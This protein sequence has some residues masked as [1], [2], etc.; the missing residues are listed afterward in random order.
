ML[1]L[2]ANKGS[3]SYVKKKRSGFFLQASSKYVLELQLRRQSSTAHFCCGIPPRWRWWL[4]TSAVALP[5]S[6]SYAS[7]S[8]HLLPAL[9][10]FTDSVGG[11]CRTQSYVPRCLAQNTSICFMQKSTNFRLVLMEVEYIWRFVIH[12]TPKPVSSIS[13]ISNFSTAMRFAFFREKSSF[14]YGKKR[15][16]KLS[17]C[18]LSLFAYWCSLR[19]LFNPQACPLLH[20]NLFDCVLLPSS[21]SFASLIRPNCSCQFVVFFQPEGKMHVFKG[22]TSSAELL[23]EVHKKQ[24]RSQNIW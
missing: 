5:P 7:G 22:K 10:V 15:P 14:S 9:Y 19:C 16:W 2:Y 8:T 21:S 3:L 20:P 17:A 23:L 18:Y 4:D 1:F 13:T 11:T 24:F 6:A 12:K